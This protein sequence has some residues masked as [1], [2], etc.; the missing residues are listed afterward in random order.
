MHVD[1]HRREDYE[2]LRALLKTRR[3][4]VADDL[5]RRLARIRDASKDARPADPLDDAEVGELDLALVEFAS[6]TL[7]RIDTAMEQLDE[8]RYGRCTRCRRAIGEA[9]LRA[10]PFAVRC[11][12]CEL[13]RE[14]DRRQAVPRRRLWGASDVAHGIMLD[15]V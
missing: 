6:A 7:K 11:H 15:E 13:A 2:R 14:G 9:R 1:H 4:E 8:G 10:M 12:E 3:A 5:Q